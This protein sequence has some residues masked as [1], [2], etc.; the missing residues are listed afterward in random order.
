MDVDAVLQL[1]RQ[2]GELGLFIGYLIWSETRRDKLN[3]AERADRA[4]RDERDI[5]S[6]EK[7]A[8]SIATLAAFIQGGKG[9]V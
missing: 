4:D 8:G 3:A 2:F 5:A 7:L 6:R 9:N 1:A